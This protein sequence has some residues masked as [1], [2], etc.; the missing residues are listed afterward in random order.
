MKKLL[1][2]ALFVAAAA[3]SFGAPITV[4]CSAPLST[5]VTSSGA[6]AASCTSYANGYSYSGGGAN[7][8]ANVALQ[9][10]ANG[11]DFSSLSTYQSVYARQAPRQTNSL[12]GAP[13]ASSISVAYS[14]TLSTDGPVRAGYLQIQGYGFGSNIYDG[15]ASMTSGIVLGGNSGYQTAVTCY[16]NSSYC[17]PGTNYYGNTLIPVTLGTAFTIQANGGT[18]DFAANFDGSSGGSLTTMYNFRFLEADG[19]TPVLVSQT[20]EP[21]TMSLIGLAFGSLLV[22]RKARTRYQR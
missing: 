13:A 14:S 11:S 18:T 1:T 19:T 7:A 2:V 9:L 16:S 6:S 5:G 10:A 20:P 15:G 17:S 21:A 22:L 12:F 4:S 3:L 8:T